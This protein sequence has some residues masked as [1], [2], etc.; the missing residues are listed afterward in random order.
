MKKLIAISVWTV[1]LL[2]CTQSFG[3]ENNNQIQQILTT[4]TLH[5][6]AIEYSDRQSGLILE[7]V[8]EMGSRIGFDEKFKFYPWIR[9]QKLIG[10]NDNWGIIPL[11][12]SKKREADYKWISLIYTDQIQFIYIDKSL[13]ITNMESAKDYTVGVVLGSFIKKILIK[14]G[15]KKIE[16]VKEHSI[17][18]KKIQGGRIFLWAVP[19]IIAIHTYKKQ[20]FDLTELKYGPTIVKMN[21]YLAGSKNISDKTVDTWNNALDSMKKDGAYDKIVNHYK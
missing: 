4:N 17:N 12:R 10:K 21:M 6:Y 9:A 20:G 14:S 13:K 19:K 2:A 15:F 16:E 1:C 3:A 5:P 8:K 18:A 11:V 7:V